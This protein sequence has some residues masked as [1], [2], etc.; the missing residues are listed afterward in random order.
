MHSIEEYVDSILIAANL[1]PRDSRR[2]REELSEHLREAFKAAR[3]RSR[4]DSEALQDVIQEFGD[5]V[6]LGR[7]IAS[8]KG[9]MRT[10]FKKNA[11]TLSVAAAAALI[12]LTLV[13]TKL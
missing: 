8:A 12:S 11:A 2:A 5:P 1:A 3:I 6:Q 7:M 10:Y 4:C 9:K 13:L